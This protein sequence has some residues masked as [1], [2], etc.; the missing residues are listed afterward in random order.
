MTPQAKTVLFIVDDE[1]HVLRAL[2]RIFERQGYRI[3]A[4]GSAVA[5][6]EG[7][8]RRRPTLIISDNYMPGVD[9]LAFLRETR[10]RFPGVRSALLTG[11]VISE[12]IKGAVATGEVDALMQKPWDLTQLVECVAELVAGA[13]RPD[14]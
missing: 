12:K 14:L 11:G 1:P 3:Y 7:L 9:G 8:R 6:R 10:Q 13:E 2:E 4:F 5:A